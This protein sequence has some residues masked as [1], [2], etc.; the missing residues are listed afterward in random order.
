MF[1]PSEQVRRCPICNAPLKIRTIDQFGVPVGYSA[2]CSHC[3]KYCDIWV[4]GLR[5][6]QCGQWSSP[7]YDSEFGAMTG[8]DKLRER[9]ILLEING[10]LLVER[11]KHWVQQLREHHDDSTSDQVIV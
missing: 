1:K 2:E 3:C 4:N 9:L 11:L 7:D 5:E 8:K 6:V 10:R